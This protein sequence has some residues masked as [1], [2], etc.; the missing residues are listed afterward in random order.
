MLE[1]KKI[2]PFTIVFPIKTGKYAET[3]RVVDEKGNKRFL[4]L[5]NLAK[6]TNTQYEQT[7]ENI[8]EINIVK[9]LSHINIVSYIDSGEVVYEGQR[10]IYMVCDFI[11]GETLFQKI[12]REGYCSVYDLKRI[13][14]GV[15][16][17]L[18][19]LHKRDIPIIHNGLTPESIMLDM[20]SNMSTAKIIDFGHAQYLESRNKSFYSDG[21]NLF[22]MAP[23]MFK[24]L[25]S[26][27]TD[28]YS[29]G[30]M[31]YHLLFGTLP[32]YVDLSKVPTQDRIARV[33]EE[34]KSPLKIPNLNIF[35]LD[36]NLLNIVAKAVSQDVDERFQNVDEFLRALNG[37]IEVSK[38]SY[39][40]VDITEA[41]PTE[42]KPTKVKKGNGFADVAGMDELKHRLNKEVIDLIK[43]PEKYKKL[44]VKIPNGMLLY[45]PPGCGKTFIAEKF[46][47]ELGCNYMYV[48]CSDVAS[49]YI[50][51][52][53]EK[54]AAVFEQAKEN[55]PTILFL[56]ELDAM[57]TDRSKHI[58]VSEYGEV[59]EF[60]TH[61]NNCAENKVFVI[62]A[63]NNPKAID[64]AALRSGRFD[65]KMYVP[66]PD[67]KNRKLL[68][69]LY[70]K[71]ISD[72]SIDYDKLVKR[73]D[74]FV[75]KD[76]ST[77]VNRA[78][79]LTAQAD[80]DKISMDALITALEKSKGELP[81]IS[82]EIL[83]Q[84]EKIREEFGDNKNNN[85]PKIGFT[86]YSSIE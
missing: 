81:S 37:E 44:K 43:C 30:V 84:H 10:C 40:K 74:G 50:H 78:A 38:A 1:K 68:F 64:P 15:L 70:L 17:G 63:T 73:S 76:I 9:S 45:G 29:V 32:W 83:K 42:A 28:L 6:L 56:D 16:N 61:L 85:R 36:D 75:S 24:G 39:T 58:S 65:I 27:R 12:K 77:L 23:E 67:E 55:A 71:D 4:K 59:N 47:E 33:I 31:M 51:G 11:V 69:E 7:I 20:T 41:K 79:I 82:A 21:L 2:G 25:Y 19:Y 49:P 60:L 66:A 5:F 72:E 54:I 8:T 57:I 62:G 14:P 53:Q 35:E 3:F 13:I 18:K 26:T 52:G 80:K 22:Y 48:H 46:A 86:S 34:R